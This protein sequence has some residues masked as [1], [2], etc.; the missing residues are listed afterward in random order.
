MEKKKIK[1]KKTGKGGITMNH[2]KMMPIIKVW[3]TDI[4]N[5]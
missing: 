5:Y 1:D 4:N 3:A 2:W